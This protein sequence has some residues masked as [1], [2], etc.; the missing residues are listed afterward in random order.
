M[1]LTLILLFFITGCT[2]ASQVT[3]HSKAPSRSAGGSTTIS[4]A[5]FESSEV[6]VIQA[7]S[8]HIIQGVVGELSETQVSASGYIIEGII[9]DR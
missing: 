9:Q 2:I 1:K 3:T 7:S 6:E 4:R 5:T 8:G